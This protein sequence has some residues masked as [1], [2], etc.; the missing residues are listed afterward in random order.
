MKI[1]KSYQLSKLQLIAIKAFADINH[2]RISAVSLLPEI[3][4]IYPDGHL[5]K[6][7]INKVVKVYN[8]NI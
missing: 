6:V 1:R 4:F 5:E 2:C 8:N 7:N 3:I